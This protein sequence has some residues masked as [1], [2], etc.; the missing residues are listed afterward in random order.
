MKILIVS[1]LRLGDIIQQ[2][3]VLRGLRQQFPEAQIDLL[4]NRQFSQAEELLKDLVHE[5]IYFDREALQK[6]LG[7]ASY[8][9]MWSYTQ[10]EG[11]IGKL[12]DSRY[13]QVY[14]FTHT[15]LSAYLVGA[16]KAENKQ[17]LYQSEGRFRGLEDPWLKYFNDRFSGRNISLFHYA[18]LL[19]HAFRIPVAREPQRE[20][21]KK[22]KRILFQCLTSDEKKN[23]GL[24]N[25]KAL[26]QT[27][28]MSLVDYRVQ[29]LGAS[30]EREKLL[31]VFDEKDVL[32]CDLSEVK[33]ILQGADLL[34]TGDTSIKHLAAQQGVPIVEISL[35]GSDP[36]K[37]GA[38]VES[39]E[40]L[41]AKIPCAPCVHSQ[42]CTQNSHRCAE[43]IDIDQVF[44]A[45]WRLLSG[46]TIRDVNFERELDRSVWQAYLDKHLQ[47]D[48][49]QLQP[50]AETLQAQQAIN[51]DLRGMLRRIEKALPK[52]ENFEKQKQISSLEVSELILCAQD[53]LRS[54]KDKAG[55]FQAYVESLTQK[56]SLPIQVYNRV[57]QALEEVRELL[58]LRERFVNDLIAPVSKEGDYYAKG[59]GQ[60][61][62]S[63]FEEARA[64]L[65]RDYQDADV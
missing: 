32:I 51:Q 38:F 49:I 17:G 15:R 30:F 11:L 59:I 39:A 64:S 12:S 8:N 47:N 10:L 41:T 29:I 58:Q 20:Q 46:E 43:A 4:L 52:K 13:D 44:A 53:I 9:F 40:V 24:Q 34:V 14:N 63:G 21:G 37:T 16:I 42:A 27:I 2:V 50:A 31:S 61:P 54:G 33:T 1:L 19:G 45:V 60:L 22:S 35:G 26:K 57:S 5:F 55:Y 3:P 6:G 36:A 7:E 62:I 23:W 48:L 28:E 56:Y 18:E 25:F 65:Q